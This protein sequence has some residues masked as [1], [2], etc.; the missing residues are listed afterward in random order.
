MATLKHIGIKNYIV[1]G[2]KVNL[3]RSFEQ[4][5]DFLVL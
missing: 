5:Y 3:F 1:Q 2:I 4:Y